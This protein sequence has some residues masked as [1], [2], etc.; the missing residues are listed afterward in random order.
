MKT[1]SQQ[2]IP[3]N[4]QLKCNVVMLPN[5]N[6]SDFRV[7]FNFNNFCHVTAC[8]IMCGRERKPFVS[9][10]RR[11]RYIYFCLAKNL[12]TFL[13]SLQTILNSWTVCTNLLTFWEQ[14]LKLE[15]RPGGRWKNFI[16][17]ESSDKKGK[18][19]ISLRQSSVML[20][21]FKQ[22]S[23]TIQRKQP[24]HNVLKHMASFS[25]C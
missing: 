16:T 25:C 14:R 4:C 2:S 10:D 9:N 1:H 20:Y 24:L 5:P 18:P 22:T 6:I 8:H 19:E 17:L 15:S 3:T 23:A 7:C 13:N 21:N 12:F 11:I